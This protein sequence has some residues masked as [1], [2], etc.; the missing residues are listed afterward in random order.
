MPSYA[1]EDRYRCESGIAIFPWR[2]THSQI[3]LTFPFSWSVFV[4]VWVCVCL[5]VAFFWIDICISYWLAVQCTLEIC[6]LHSLQFQ[7]ADTERPIPYWIINKPS[8][9]NTHIILEKPSILCMDIFY[10]VYT[11]LLLLWLLILETMHFL[12][13]IQLSL[14]MVDRKISDK[15][16]FVFPVK[17]LVFKRHLRCTEY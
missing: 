16:V 6:C 2:V 9:Q 4:H 8:R 17:V 7:T 1:P 12:C 5:P 10:I 14:R 15:L 13:K 3:T 11:L